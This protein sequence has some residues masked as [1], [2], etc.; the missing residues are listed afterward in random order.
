MA[1][2][3]TTMEENSEAE[4]NPTFAPYGALNTQPWLAKLAFAI[5]VCLAVVVFLTNGAYSAKTPQKSMSLDWQNKGSIGSI[6]ANYGGTVSAGD[7]PVFN[8]NGHNNFDQSST[9]NGNNFGGTFNGNFDNSKISHSIV[10]KGNAKMG[11]IHQTNTVQNLQLSQLKKMVKDIPSSREAKE[12]FYEVNREL[13]HDS[14][15]FFNLTMTLLFETCHSEDAKKCE[16]KAKEQR[17]LWQTTLKLKLSSSSQVIDAVVKGAVAKMMCKKN[18]STPMV[19][20]SE[21]VC[22][23]YNLWKI[24]PQDGRRLRFHSF[25]NPCDSATKP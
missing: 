25:P 2:V 19:A 24:N 18:T 15:V 14:R 4:L 22:E 6:G 17:D 3:D 13:L 5:S 12:S 10:A 21:A 1:D 9:I 23:A 7:N 8:Y 20:L 16:S 11:D